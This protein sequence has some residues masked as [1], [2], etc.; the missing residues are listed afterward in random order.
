MRI[1]N[2][3][4]LGTY[5]LNGFIA[6]LQAYADPARQN[7]SDDVDAVEPFFTNMLGVHLTTD[8]PRSSSILRLLDG[9]LTEC[10]MDLDTYDYHP[11]DTHVA[12]LLKGHLACGGEFCARFLVLS[13][14]YSHMADDFDELLEARKLAI[15][16]ML[17]LGMFYHFNHFS[18]QYL[19]GYISI[20]V[21]FDEFMS[22]VDADYYELTYSDFH[23]IKTYFQAKREQATPA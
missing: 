5:E 10:F 19:K 3:A 18:N 7:I 20:D 15:I 1:T 8:N 21:L 23:V 13:H 22:Y 2:L 9:V 16:Q 4:K 11:L 17:N 12:K 14:H 6:L